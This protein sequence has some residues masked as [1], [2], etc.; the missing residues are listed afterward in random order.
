VHPAP[1]P[2]VVAGNSYYLGIGYDHQPATLVAANNDRY[3]FRT[4]N[5]FVFGGHWTANADA[6]FALG[7]Q[8]NGDNP[9]TNYRSLHG[10]RA[11]PTYQRLVDRKGNSLPVFTD[12]NPD[13]LRSLSQLSYPDEYYLPLDD[14]RKEQNTV[15]TT[16]YTFS[17]GLRWQPRSGE[18]FEFG[19][20]AEYQSVLNK[21]AFGAS[22]YYVRDLQNTFAQRDS[23]GNFSYP[24]PTGGIETVTNS[25]LVANQ[26]RLQFNLHPYWGVN[27]RL[28]ALAGGEL[29]SEVNTGYSF[30]YYGFDDGTSSVNSTVNFNTPY[31]S[32]LT[33]QT[34]DIPNPQSISR[35]TDHFLSGYMEAMYVDH[36]QL[37]VTVTLRDDA[38]NLFGVRTNQKAMPLW[39]T[40][41]GYELDSLPFY[42]W[43]AVPKLKLRL[44]YG[45]S[46]NID[47]QASAYT[48]ASYSSSGLTTPFPNAT[49][50]SPP[51]ENL[52]WERVAQFDGGLD[53]T[54]DSG[55]LSG[56]IDYYIKSSSDLMGQAPLN[57][58]LGVITSAGS[59]SYFYGNV[60]AMYGYGVD[61]QLTTHWIRARKVRW[62]MVFIVSQTVSKVTR[63]FLP[64]G[65]GNAYLNPNLINPVPGRPLYA[66]YSF[67]WAGLDPATGDPR[68]YYN[69]KA[70]SSW[71]SI[72]AN[73]NLISMY[74]KGS[75]EPV[76]YGSL[77]NTVEWNHWG[78][79]TL[80]SFKLDY[81]FRRPSINYGDLLTVW[82]GNSDYARRWQNSGDERR[83]NVPSA[84]YNA[85]PARD[86]IYT[87]SSALVDKADNIR[88][89]D[90]RV[91]RDLAFGLEKKGVKK[92]QLSLYADAANLGIIWK[93]NKDGIDPYFV[94][95]PKDNRRWSVGFKGTF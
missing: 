41:L 50:V 4:N 43:Q 30:C 79:T 80:I 35:T 70:S 91:N 18:D 28:T 20:S 63:Y 6:G 31:F 94:N 72:W 16:D 82:T 37:F 95:V 5:S 11:F 89:E 40:G 29:R 92:H 71:D 23:S 17:G 60:A 56:T 26:A 77:R 34:S 53:F 87:Y 57:P 54:V 21:N 64:T 32:Y 45:I 48:I 58:T 83:T 75:S 47:R 67:R 9:G 85:D 65:A 36:Q 1:L 3:T 19:Y 55:L 78:L 33:G 42:H 7:V 8:S 76:W 39:S 88:L 25:A 2:P 15:Q 51:N 12:Y 61:C 81:Y 38:A 73:T 49:I 69:G 13:Y 44:S 46:G 27:H 68:A 10:G 59:P 86:N 74:Y 22:A 14:I 24:I 66:V 62:H 52:R 93:A 84:V 90:I